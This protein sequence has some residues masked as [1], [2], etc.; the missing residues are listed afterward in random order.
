MS[1]PMPGYEKRKVLID[2]LKH[3]S[4]LS[5][6]V[7]ALSAAFLG[8]LSQL[9]GGSQPIIFAVVCFFTVVVSSSVAKYIL[10][11]NIETVPFLS[12][13]HYLLRACLLLSFVGFFSGAGSFVYIVVKNA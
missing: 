4:T 3:F 7:L 1:D 13:S 9:S 6:G 10:V 5:I 8:N 12:F 2:L 11:A